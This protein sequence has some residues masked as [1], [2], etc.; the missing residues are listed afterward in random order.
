MTPTFSIVLPTFNRAYVLWKAVQSVLDQNESCWELLVVDDGSDDCTE[1]LL[2]EF[3]D[4]RVRVVRTERRGPSAARNCGLRLARAPYVAYIDSDNTWHPNFLSVMHEA[5]HSSPEC[6]LW[7]YGQNTNMWDRTREGEW[8][9]VGVWTD[10]REQYTLEDIWQWNGADT[11]CIVHERSVAEEIGGWDE[12]CRWM[13]D[14]D[15][16][17]RVFLRYPGMQKWVPRVLVEYRQVHG[18]GADGLCAEARRNRDAEAAGRRYL[19]EK[20]SAHPGFAAADKLNRTRDA[21]PRTRV[22]A[23]ALGV[24]L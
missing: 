21:L 6:V 9:H 5:I 8:T 14:W 18:D 12:G 24:E 1:R 16:L 19:Y 2:E 13:E 4:S 22:E 23:A 15:F 10:A 7:Y 11:N 17:L 20:W 3:R